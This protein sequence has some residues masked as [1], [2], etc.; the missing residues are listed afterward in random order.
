MPGG[1]P[2]LSVVVPVFDEEENLALLVEAVEEALKGVQRWELILIDDGSSDAT[3]DIALECAARNPRVRLVSLARRCG[4]SIAMQAGF[5]SARASVLVTL[6]GDLQNDPRDIPRLVA[7]LEKGYDLVVGFREKRRDPLFSRRLPSWIANRLIGLITGVRV[8]DNGCSLKAYRRELLDRMQLYS[9]LHRFIPAVAV[10]TAGARIAE[11]PVRHHPR[12]RGR[13][14]YGLSRVA[15]VL[16]DL[17][18]V[19]MIRSSGSNPFL[20][21]GTAA[22]VAALLGLAFL[23]LAIRGQAAWAAVYARAL[24]LPGV[25]FL[26]F[27]LAAF[28]VMLGLIGQV[29]VSAN[30]GTERRRRPILHELSP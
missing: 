19:T 5:D 22:L 23:G 2:D 25:S 18:T 4:Q 30:Q 1:K 6:D 10:G 20:P 11:I 24:V 28:L 8:R 21:F 15:T 17:V 3:A 12:L 9:D 29:A 26:W 13:S 14:K 7:E 16:V 27:A